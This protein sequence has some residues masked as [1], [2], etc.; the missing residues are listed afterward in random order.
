MKDVSITVSIRITDDDVVVA[1][2]APST[3]ADETALAGMRFGGQDIVALAL[4]SEA[5]RRQANLMVGLVA[6]SDPARTA[7]LR[8]GDV[9]EIGVV[10]TQ[11]LDVLTGVVGQVATHAVV[12]AVR[13]VTG[14]KPDETV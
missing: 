5:I 10:T 3:V 11:V 6:A 12:G 9:K 1:T 14:S 2:H 8:S 4:L 13:D 7:L